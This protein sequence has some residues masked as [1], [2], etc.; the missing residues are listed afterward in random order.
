MR[1]H[2]HKTAATARSFLDHENVIGG[3]GDIRTFPANPVIAPGNEVPN[4]GL[5]SRDHLVRTHTRHRRADETSSMAVR[6]P[7]P[8]R[9]RLV[10]ARLTIKIKL[11]LPAKSI[12]RTF[13]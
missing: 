10:K 3:R 7:D 9:E 5:T 1:V 11:N 12:F 4:A 13:R 2:R 6:R 8:S